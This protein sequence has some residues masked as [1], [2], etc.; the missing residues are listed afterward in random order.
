MVIIISAMAANRV[1]GN[2]G[3][4][5]WAVPEEYEQYL[6]FVKDQ[7]VIMGRKS[8]EIFKKDLTSK[9]T[10]VISRSESKLGTAMIYSGIAEA[11][12]AAKTLGRT[13]FVAGGASIYQQ[14]L[15]FVDKM[16]ISYIKGDYEGDVFFPEFEVNQW[17]EEKTED[18]ER[19][20]FVVY[21]RS[22]PKPS[23]GRGH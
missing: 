7:T 3:Q 17:H 8:Y 9:Y 19:F 11:I 18:H 1:I 15:S 22:N 14:A 4:L 21:T 2:R 20:R 23:I 6:N 13:V 12:E 10:I 5:P 16:Y